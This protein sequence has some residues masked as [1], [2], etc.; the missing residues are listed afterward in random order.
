[1][2]RKKSSNWRLHA[3]FIFFDIVFMMLSYMLAI[4]TRSDNNLK[5]YMQMDIYYRGMFLLAIICFIELV[6]TN[7][8]DNVLRRGKYVEFVSTFKH[9]IVVLMFFIS[10]MFI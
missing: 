10:I 2:Y 3:D 4:I 5:G 8:Y 9:V 7:G 1:M 6:V